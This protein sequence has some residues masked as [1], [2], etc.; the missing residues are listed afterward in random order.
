MI[1]LQIS[2]WTPVKIN[3]NIC[4][5]VK[6]LLFHGGKFVLGHHP[7]Y[8]QFTVNIQQIYKPDNIN[9]INWISYSSIPPLFNIFTDNRINEFLNLF[10]LQREN[11][12]LLQEGS[13][14]YSV[15]FGSLS[16][17]GKEVVPQNLAIHGPSHTYSAVTLSHVQKCTPKAWCYHPH[18]SQ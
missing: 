13:N 10:N 4:K 5:Q 17:S 3:V 1:Q 11:L 18:A 2:I 14:S 6:T 9:N 12:N 15:Y 7:C 8:R 16:W